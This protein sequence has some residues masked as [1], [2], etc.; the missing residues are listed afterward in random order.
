VGDALAGS[1]LFAHLGNG[2]WIEALLQSRRSVDATVLAKRPNASAGFNGSLQGVNVVGFGA[3]DGNGC[4]G[5]HQI[6]G[7]TIEPWL[8]IC[9]QLAELQLRITVPFLEPRPLQHTRY[10]VSTQVILFQDVVQSEDVAGVG[11]R[12]GGVISLL[13]FPAASVTQRG[14]LEVLGDLEGDPDASSY[15][16]Q[17]LQEEMMIL[18]IVEQLG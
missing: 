10:E 13:T 5:S 9:G 1:H 12:P 16:K 17:E 2:F 11:T 14:W 7:Y 18:I 4:L 6:N 15:S 8:A 3:R